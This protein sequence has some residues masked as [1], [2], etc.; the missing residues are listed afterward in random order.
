MHHITPDID[1]ERSKVVRDLNVAGCVK[2]VHL[3]PRPKMANISQ[4]FDGR[5]GQHG[6]GVGSRGTEGMPADGAGTGV[7][8]G[9]SAI[10]A[11]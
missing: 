3:V 11:R 9:V 7:G 6:W 8:N 4:N 1:E 10:Q 5:S 2:A